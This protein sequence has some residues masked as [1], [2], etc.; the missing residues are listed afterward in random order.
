MADIKVATTVASTAQSAAILVWNYY[1]E[2]SKKKKMFVDIVCEMK[3]DEVHQLRKYI[4]IGPTGSGKS[5]LAKLWAKH[6]EKF[7]S[8]I[9]VDGVSQ[10]FVVGFSNWSNDE[11]I[12]DTIGLNSTSDPL[13]ALS[14]LDKHDPSRV[15]ILAKEVV[16]LINPDRFKHNKN[17]HTNINDLVYKLNLRKHPANVFAVLSCQSTIYKNEAIEAKKDGFS[18]QNWVN[19]WLRSK[20][21]EEKLI[22]SGEMM[23]KRQEKKNE[24]WADIIRSCKSLDFIRADN[25]EIMDCSDME[26]PPLNKRSCQPTQITYGDSCDIL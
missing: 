14:I 4:L 13:D 10:Q 6:P 18:G 8:D 21:N 22:I 9:N 1:K 23:R 25:V 12:V 2:Q 19:D 17:W 15:G 7:E 5:Y 11:V 24:F 3:M 16:I 20:T 26:G